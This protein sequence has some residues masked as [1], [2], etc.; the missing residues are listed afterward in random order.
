MV[1]NEVIAIGFNKVLAKVPI[2]R[3]NLLLFQ[4][5]YQ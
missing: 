5:Q 3:I 1:Q 2:V 4:L